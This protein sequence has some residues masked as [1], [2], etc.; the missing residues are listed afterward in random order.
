[1]TLADYALAAVFALNG[2][3]C[4]AIVAFAV[5]KRR[6]ATLRR[7]DLRQWIESHRHQPH[8]AVA[9]AAAYPPGNLTPSARHRDEMIRQGLFG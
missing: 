2:T 4:L 7:P 6:D 5:S 1:M 3:A 9:E 8:G